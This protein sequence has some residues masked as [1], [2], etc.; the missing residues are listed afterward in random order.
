MKQR[1]FQDGTIRKIIDACPST[2]RKELLAIRDLIFQTAAE[3]DEI[4]DIEETLKW[5]QPSYLTVSPKSGTTIRLSALS[6]AD[7]KFAISVHC[8]TSLISDFKVK[9]PKLDYDG[10]RSIILD[11]RAGLPLDA[12]KHFIYAALTYHHRKKMGITI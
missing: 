3:F 9:Y 1:I 6:S 11:V 2:V 12:I 8:Q 4:G 5:D 10:N 7:T